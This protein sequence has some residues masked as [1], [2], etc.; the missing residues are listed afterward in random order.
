[1]HKHNNKDDFNDIEKNK[2]NIEKLI[3]EYS[4]LTQGQII[5]KL[6]QDYN[7]SERDLAKRFNQTRYKIRKILKSVEQ[8]N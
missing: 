3:G 1:M 8:P 4:N 7:V 2:H 6:K 5:I